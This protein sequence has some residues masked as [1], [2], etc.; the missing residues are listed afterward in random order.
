MDPRLKNWEPP[1]PKSVN[2]ME[3]GLRAW[4]ASIKARDSFMCQRCGCTDHTRLTI[5]HIVPLKENGGVMKVPDDQVCTM[6]R[7]CQQYIHAVRKWHNY[8][9]FLAMEEAAR[10]MGVRL[11]ELQRMV[12]QNE[13]R[14]IKIAGRKR[15]P[16]Y[17]IRA[18]LSAGKE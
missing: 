10:E 6:C 8:S 16:Y 15:I 14:A 7:D 17:A 13:I 11:S 18:H 3:S 12:R 1:D 2:I 5:H 4:K 9:P